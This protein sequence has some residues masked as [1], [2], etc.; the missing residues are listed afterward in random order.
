MKLMII[1]GVS[2]AGKSQALRVLEDTDF[3]CV[4]NLPV[5]MIDNFAKICRQS[6]PPI[7]N[8]ALVIDCRDSSFAA[9]ALTALKSLS[10]SG[11]DYELLFLDCSDEVLLRRFSETRR[12]H[13]LDKNGLLQEAITRER[14]ILQPIKEMATYII[15][16]SRLRPNEF[17]RVLTEILQSTDGGRFK[18]VV[19]SFGYKR[20]LPADADFVMDMRFLPNPFYV[21]EL[22]MKSGLDKEVKDYVLSFEL[23]NRFLDEFSEITKQ[24]CPLFIGQGKQRLHIAFGCTGGRHRSV[25]MA[26]AYAERL[27][28]DFESITVYH[29]DFVQ[30]AGDLQSRFEGR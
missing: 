6:V 5:V 8:A 10:E 24:I 27:R 28:Q 29:R 30:E 9:T 21:P 12:E 3:F 1:T 2:G 23:A 20:G 26:E 22:R 17:K 19:S 16:T 11:I 13:P 4:D 25:A 7:E 18:L 14:E 15:D